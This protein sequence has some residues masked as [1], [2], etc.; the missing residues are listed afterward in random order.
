[1]M[2]D[3]D[4]NSSGQIAYNN[5]NNI[6]TF[7]TNGAE[8]MRIDS[9]GNVGIGTSSPNRALTVVSASGVPAELQSTS[10]TSLLAFYDS[11]TGVRPSIGSS[12][13]NLV[14]N[15]NGSERMRIDSSGN[16]LVGTT[17]L[18][19]A[20]NTGI[21]A[22]GNRA[23]YLKATSSSGGDQAVDIEHMATSGTRYLVY[24]R[25]NGTGIG[26][27]TSTGSS[28]AYNTTSDYRLKTDVQPMT[29]ATERLKALKPVNFEW[30]SSGERVDGFLAHE[31]QEVVPE[32]VTGTKDAMRTEEYEVTPAEYEDVLIPAVL[33][34]EG[35]EIEP[36][37]TEQRLVTEAVMGERE[38]P[39]YQGIDQSKL[40]PLLV[41]AMQEQ[42]AVIEDLT[43]RIEAL[44][45]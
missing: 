16:L 30:I 31:A 41:A 9:S 20:S 18:N 33:D 22:H 14:A 13:S 36:E 1:M 19:S 5:T 28:T 38:V 12:G 10:T 42:Q 6:M 44:E 34:D 3:T 39:D 29:G 7:D 27:I 35:N 11:G 8:A 37:R 32:A 43:A 24:F 23:A 40:V 2:G 15:V 45:S 26:S 17:S 4:A 25:I 21:T